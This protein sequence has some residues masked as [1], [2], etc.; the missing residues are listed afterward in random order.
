[1]GL[2]LAKLEIYRDWAGT[3]PQ[4]KKLGSLAGKWEL[5]AHLLFIK[6]IV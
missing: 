4:V 2:A 1:M 6:R 5:M 3:M